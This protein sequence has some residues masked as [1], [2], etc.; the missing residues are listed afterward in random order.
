MKTNILTEID[1]SNMR[2]ALDERIVFLLRLL[3]RWAPEVEDTLS[4]Y[5]KVGGYFTKEDFEELAR[6]GK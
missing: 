3:G 4:A 6:R 1:M 5:Q 2:L